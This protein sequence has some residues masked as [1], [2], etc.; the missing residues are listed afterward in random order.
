MQSGPITAS[1]AAHSRDPFAVLG[2]LERALGDEVDDDLDFV[3]NGRW[4]DV[5]RRAVDEQGVA[6]DGR[7]D[8]QLVHDA[9]RYA[10]RSVLGALAESCEVE[11]PSLD[12][13]TPAPLP[14]RGRRWST[15]LHRS[16]WSSTPCLGCRS[17]RPARLRPRRCTAPIRGDGGGF[18][19]TGS[20]NEVGSSSSVDPARPGATH[21]VVDLGPPIDRHRQHQTAGVVGVV[22]DQVDAPRRP[23]AARSCE[24]S[25]PVPVRR[26]TA[27]GRRRRTGPA[28]RG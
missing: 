27:R 11:R 28:T 5:E 12:V 19:T 7:R 18:A 20:S 8:A 3:G 10:G 9:G 1:A 26:R 2:P 16:G 14:P 24:C 22:T 21:G 17:S 4:C 13:P 23:D 6:L 25:Q 15:V